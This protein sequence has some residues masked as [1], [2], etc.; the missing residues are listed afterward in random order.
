MKKILKLVFLNLTAAVALAGLVAGCAVPQ[1][2]KS[3]VRCGPTYGEQMPQ[4]RRLGVVS[5]VVVIYDRAS[6]NDYVSI[7][8]S[9]IAATNMLADAARHLKSKGY[10]VAFVDGPLV[11]A[12]KPANTPMQAANQRHGEPA[13]RVTPLVV[14]SSSAIARATT[15]GVTRLAGSP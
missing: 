13:N 8:D 11:G 7:E 6:T 1:P 2:T 4:A 5:D 12:F 3:F 9:L 14:A 15:R 10:E